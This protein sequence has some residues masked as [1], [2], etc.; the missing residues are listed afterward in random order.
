MAHKWENLKRRMNPERR[1]RIEAAV[2]AE[3]ESMPLA[4]IRKAIGMTQADLAGKL[5]TGQGS[6]SKIENAADMYLTTL[7]KYIQALGGELH[8]TASFPGGRNIDIDALSQV[9]PR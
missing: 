7:R 9:A 5:D 8:L 3:L 1:A 6:V 2:K 4:E